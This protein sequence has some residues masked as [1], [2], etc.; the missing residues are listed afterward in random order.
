MNC[1]SLPLLALI[2]GAVPC[3]GQELPRCDLDH[4]S[5]SV[6]EILSNTQGVDFAPY[7]TNVLHSV[8]QTWYSR[9]PN[10]ALFP[11]LERGCVAIRFSVLKDGS[12]HDTSYEFVSGNIAMDRAAYDGINGAS[13]FAPLPA[14]FAGTE[15]KLR[16]WFK[17][18][19]NHNPDKPPQ[20]KSAK[21]NPTSH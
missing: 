14:K 1:L 13:P 8:K 2:L 19:P 3:S 7:L 6:L 10:E 20:G 12:V 17:Y 11:R 18:N 15:I 4:V 9:I 5:S 21:K 16:F